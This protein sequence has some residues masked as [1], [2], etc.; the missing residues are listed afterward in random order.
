M[1]FAKKNHNHGFQKLVKKLLGETK[2]HQRT[3]TD[4]CK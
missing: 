1:P 2:Q 3:P 4:F